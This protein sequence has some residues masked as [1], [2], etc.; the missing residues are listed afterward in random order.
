MNII[1]VN[2]NDPSLSTKE[3]IV[4]YDGET[5]LKVKTRTI[6]KGKFSSLLQDIYDIEQSQSEIQNLFDIEKEKKFTSPNEVIESLKQKEALRKTAREIAVSQLS[7]YRELVSWCVVDVE[8]SYDG[9]RYH[10]NFRKENWLNQSYDVLSE[11]SLIVYG[12]VESLILL[13]GQHCILFQLNLLKD[14]N[15]Q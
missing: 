1:S 12:M 4:P 8:L 13:L 7:A 10:P 3:L 11:E 15:I 6:P 9:K 14:E 5:K 2:A